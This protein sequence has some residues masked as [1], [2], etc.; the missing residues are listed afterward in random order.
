MREAETKECVALGLN[1]MRG[2][3]QAEGDPN[4]L[5]TIDAKG[6]YSHD[7]M[8]S[9]Y[10]D[11]AVRTKFRHL[12]LTALYPSVITRGIDTQSI[13]AVTVDGALYMTQISRQPM[14]TLVE[15]ACAILLDACHMLPELRA[16][17]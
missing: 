10:G 5:R 8:I 17:A 6:F 15:D 7:L 11:P 3:V 14:P 1:T 9:N 4:D 16:L 12:T 13:S 2:V